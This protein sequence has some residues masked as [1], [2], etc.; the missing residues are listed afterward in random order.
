MSMRLT[1]DEQAW[2]DAYCQ[3]LKEQYPGMVDR[4]VAVPAPTYVVGMDTE[5]EAGFLLSVNEP[6]GNV[7]SLMT[8]FQIDCNAVNCNNEGLFYSRRIGRAPQLGGL[9]G[10]ASS[11]TATGSSS[12]C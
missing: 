4:M 5:L 9:Y 8:R 11:P 12:T 10:D 6:R 2:L 7:A 1:A 3:A